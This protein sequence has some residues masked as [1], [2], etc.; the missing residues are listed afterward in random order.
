[1]Q[2][3]SGLALVLFGAVSTGC[4]GIPALD[5]PAPEAGADCYRLEYSVRSATHPFPDLV[6]LGPAETSGRAAWLPVDHADSSRLRGFTLGGQWATS[7]TSDSIRATFGSLSALLELRAVVSQGSIR[8]VAA[9]HSDR[10]GSPAAFVGVR[11]AC[12]R[13]RAT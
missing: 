2:A 1:V 13:S 8:G 7:S 3:S 9:W 10:P 11:V 6:A 4:A 5:V 12:P